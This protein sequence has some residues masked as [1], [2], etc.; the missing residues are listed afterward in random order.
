M[1]EYVFSLTCIILH[2][3]RI[4]GFVFIRENT[5]LKIL[6][7]YKKISSDTNYR[8]QWFGWESKKFVGQTVRVTVWLKFDKKQE[9]STT[10]N[11]GINICGSKSN[12]FLDLCDENKWCYVTVVGMCNQSSRSNDRVK[13]TF[14]GMPGNGTVYIFQ[15]KAQIL[16]CSKFIYITRFW[17]VRTV[18]PKA[19]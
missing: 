16:Q 7:L 1:P 3:D 8:K 15:L 18:S 4:F 5:G 14:N 9:K 13:L 11:F 6:V 10:N 19:S 2:M 12:K 17:L